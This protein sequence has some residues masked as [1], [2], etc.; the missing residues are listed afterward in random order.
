RRDASPPA[1]SAAKTCAKT[2]A[3]ATADAG[4]STEAHAGAERRVEP[5][6]DAELG[7][8]AHAE[9][10]A[11]RAAGE[12]RR[13][14]QLD[15]ERELEWRARQAS[16]VFLAIPLGDV[17]RHLAIVGH[18]PRHRRQR[19]APGDEDG[20]AVLGRL[21]DAVLLGQRDVGAGA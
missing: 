16:R 14:Q 2:D 17:A 6:A 8:D 15:L 12:R 7:V 18:L 11:E 21:E 10:H 1:D 13:R 9:R 5:Y 4:A 19:E 3:D 20:L